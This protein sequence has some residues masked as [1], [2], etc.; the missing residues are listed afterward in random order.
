MATDRTDASAKNMEAV[1]KAKGAHDAECPY[2]QPA[3]EV[4]LHPFD[5]E[6]M[7]WEPGDVIVGLT[8][9]DDT[10]V[11][12]GMLRVVCAGETDD[13]PELTTARGRDIPAP[14]TYAGALG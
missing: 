1:V 10:K 11:N 7:G 4:H 13:E 14:A 6:R 9:V 5:L 12:T 3:V 2:G 8:V